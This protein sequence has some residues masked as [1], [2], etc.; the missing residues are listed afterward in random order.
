LLGIDFE[1]A[2]KTEIT[3]LTPVATKETATAIVT[4]RGEGNSDGA[5]EGVRF[6]VVLV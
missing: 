3:G 4:T 6:L 5:K 2:N 1:G